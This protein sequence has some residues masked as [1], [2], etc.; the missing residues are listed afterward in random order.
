MGS[1][2]KDERKTVAQIKDDRL[3]MGDKPDYFLLRGTVTA[4]RRENCL[5]QVCVCV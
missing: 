4:I 5:Y 1:G 2:R 3:G